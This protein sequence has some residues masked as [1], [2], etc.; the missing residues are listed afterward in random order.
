MPT[1]MLSSPKDNVVSAVWNALTFQRRTYY[2]VR[3]N[4]YSYAERPI[5]LQI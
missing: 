3:E 1:A 5:L 2:T 4:E